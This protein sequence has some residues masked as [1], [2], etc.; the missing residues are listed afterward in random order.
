VAAIVGAGFLVHATCWSLRSPVL[1]VIAVAVTLGVSAI[2][3]WGAKDRDR[4][5]LTTATAALA[6]L[7]AALVAGYQGATFAQIGVV[8]AAIAAALSAT[9]YVLRGRLDAALQ[10]VVLAAAACAIGFS[11]SEPAALAVVAGLLIVAPVLGVVLATDPLAP[12]L[13]QALICLEAD[14]VHRW[15]AAD[16]GLGSRAFIIA[17]TAAAV[18]VPACRKRD[19]GARITGPT[20]YALAV[21]GTIAG[22]QVDPMWLALLV[23]GVA[24]ALIAALGAIAG[25]RTPGVGATPDLPIAVH[26]PAALSSFLLL[27]SSWV[28]LAESHIH[29]VEPYTLPAALVLLAAGNVRRR[30][31]R[32]AASWPCYGPGLVV[33][34]APTLIQALADPGLVRPALLGV[35]ALLVLIVGVRS[36]LQ[37]PLAVGATV[38][39]IDVVAQ[40]SPALAAA[41]DAVPR[42][43]LI[44]AAG[45]LL[46]ALGVTYERR[47]RDLRVLGQ[48]LG[49]LR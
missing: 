21:V 44:A 23:G 34:F 49:R 39:A 14:T 36:R 2:A 3:A 22:R 29:S 8:L 40:L 24:A 19:I 41:Y 10:M 7:E 17:L 18:S 46:L 37:A 28:R 31:D 9:S 6:A 15:M 1:T 16:A 12:V 11:A 45:A 20:I 26:L 32:E 35:V 25:Q 4:L 43:T 38:L 48:K 33:G 27:A 13:L 30:A 5:V 42:W 47:I